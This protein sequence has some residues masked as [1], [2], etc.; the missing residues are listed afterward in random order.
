MYRIAKCLLIMN[1]FQITN[2]A[3]S[4]KEFDQ[5]DFGHIYYNSPTEIHRPKNTEELALTLKSYNKKGVK[6]KIRNT[7]H[8]ANGQTL[9]DGV[10]INVGDIKFTKFDEEKLELTAG[11]GNSWDDLFKAV[12]FPEYSLPIF[13]S[14][15]NQQIHAGGT[16][17]IGGIG[18][19]ST[20]YGGAWR[21]IK[22]IKLVTMTGEIIECSP[23]KHKEYFQFALSGFGRI[24]VTSEITFEIMK[25]SNRVIKFF[26]LYN[27]LLR[28]HLDLDLAL[29]MNSFTG[30]IPG[31]ILELG[32]LEIPFGPRHFLIL[33]KEVDD[34]FDVEGFTKNV[35]DKF[36]ENFMLISKTSSN[37]DK[38]TM[39]FKGSTV[40]KHSLV[41]SYMQVES[42]MHL[43]HP[44]TELIIDRENYEHLYRES[45]NIGRKFGIDCY[46]TKCHLIE[47]YLDIP[48]LGVYTMKSF[49]NEHAEFPL[50][51]LI[52][53]K[54]YSFGITF[55]PN[56]PFENLENT[57]KACD[58]LNDLTYE[59]GGKR[60]MH[61]YHKLSKLQVEKQYGLDIIKKWN[62]IKD[63]LDPKHLLNI[64]VIEHLD[65]Y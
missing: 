15:P 53:G 23:H 63:E 4:N 25:S 56:V 52:P 33:Y 38:E 48:F 62:K 6:V 21:H 10:Q 3:F 2:K 20:Q 50:S 32:N 13:P 29:S 44:W 41:Y 37:N 1:N 30:I 49:E 65:N 43:A 51:T 64:G 28:S 61:G 42:Q 12:N 46:H 22:K 9:T 36:H 14:N 8:S 47:D 58:Y 27:D 60:Y 18:F 24:G 5:T 16:L 35:R 40:T 31:S 19:F 39:T 34:E 54:E 55:D 11:V 59:L 26:L 45:L 17:S 7:G 57:L